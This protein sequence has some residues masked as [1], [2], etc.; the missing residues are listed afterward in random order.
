MGQ[1]GRRIIEDRFTAQ[2]MVDRLVGFYDSLLE[3]KNA[4]SFRA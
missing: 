2:E 4:R 3:A 1:A